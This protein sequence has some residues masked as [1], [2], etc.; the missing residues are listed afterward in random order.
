M[1]P[2]PRQDADDYFSVHSHD[3]DKRKRIKKNR[4]RRGEHNVTNEPTDEQHLLRTPP[5]RTSSYSEDREECVCRVD[6]A[7]ALYS[8]DNLK[9]HPQSDRIDVQQALP[10]VSSTLS[11]DSG[12]SPART[13]LRRLSQRQPT[14]AD[15]DAHKL[16]R[17]S[18]ALSATFSVFKSRPSAKE[19]DSAGHTSRR[20]NR[21]FSN[22]KKPFRKNPS[23]RDT[24]SKLADS[25][26]GHKTLFGW[27]TPSSITLRKASIA[28]VSSLPRTSM[29]ASI[30]CED[31]D[32]MRDVDAP[33]SELLAFYSSLADEDSTLRTFDH[34]QQIAPMQAASISRTRSQFEPSTDSRRHSGLAATIITFADVHVAPRTFTVSPKPRKES[35]AAAG[36]PARRISVVQFRSRN[37][38]HEVVW[39]EDETSSGSSLG[40]SL[41]TSASPQSHKSK[42]SSPQMETTPAQY[43]R[44][45]TIHN[46][47]VTPGTIDQPSGTLFQWSWSKDNERKDRRPYLVR[48]ASA[49]N[50]ELARRQN[51]SNVLHTHRRSVSDSQ[52]ILSFPP[53]RDRSSTLEWCRAPPVDLND[54]LAGSATEENVPTLERHTGTLSEQTEIGQAKSDLVMLQEGFRGRRA[55]SHPYAPARIGASGRVGSSIGSSSHV[56][57]MHSHKV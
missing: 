20:H 33:P 17:M 1:S 45:A 11:N 4:R 44:L 16:R 57:M 2:P 26:A 54:P 24:S 36:Q 10:G 13:A 56:R 31:D 21:T 40:T 52:E 43:A 12:D 7:G 47:P 9:N 50:P 34:V 37:S 27:P 19:I 51:C 5:A 23:H 25:S 6:A 53:L 22:S 3:N 14:G 15:T 30:T 38:V 18:T 32:R 55:S 48:M 8:S 29:S 28:R 46:I 42:A 41:Q 49:S 35:L 39:R